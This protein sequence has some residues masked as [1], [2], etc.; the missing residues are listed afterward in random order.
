M[1]QCHL[2]QYIR[3]IQTFFLNV[4]DPFFNSTAIEMTPEILHRVLIAVPL[5]SDIAFIFVFSA[6]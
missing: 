5:S 1:Y 4:C 2:Y 3:K 6:P